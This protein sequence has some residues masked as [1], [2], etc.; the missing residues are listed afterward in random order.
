[1]VMLSKTVQE[2]AMVLQWKTAPDCAQVMY[3]IDILSIHRLFRRVG[4]C[5]RL[6]IQREEIEHVEGGG[7]KCVSNSFSMSM[8]L[9]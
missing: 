5:A 1:M 4:V 7:N 9:I 2:L 8:Q 3:D 6:W